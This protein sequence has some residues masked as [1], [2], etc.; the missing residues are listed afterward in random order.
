MRMAILMGV[1]SLFDSETI[2]H[3]LYVLAKLTL[4]F[5]CNVTK[6]IAQYLARFT[7]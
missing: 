3:S 2:G 6:G 7:V 4:I 5:R 1:A